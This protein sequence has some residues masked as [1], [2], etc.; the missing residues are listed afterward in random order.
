MG[1]PGFR[2]LLEDGEEVHEFSRPPRDFE[3]TGDGG[4]R[5]TIEPAD[6]HPPLTDWLEASESVTV[7]YHTD[8][9]GEARARFH[10]RP[11]EPDRIA[12][13]DWMERPTQ[14][15]LEPLEG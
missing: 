10:L 7:D 15:I 11:S 1:M 6:L 4:Y 5:F 2:R 14:V 12:G 13:S 8:V 3:E 9:D